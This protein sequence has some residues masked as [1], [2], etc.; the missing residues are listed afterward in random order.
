[1]EF[2]GQHVN[3]YSTVP[4]HGRFGHSAGLY[5]IFPINAKLGHGSFGHCVCLCSTVPRHGR[6]GHQLDLYSF[7][8][9]AFQSKPP[10]FISNSHLF[11]I[12]YASMRCVILLM[13][14]CAV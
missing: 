1:M 9:Q 8:F 4:R 12:A 3:I 10:C 13:H 2:L 11:N 5:S 6:L 14:L 7:Q